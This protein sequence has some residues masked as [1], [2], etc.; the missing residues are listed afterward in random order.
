MFDVVLYSTIV[1]VCARQQFGR[2]D[3][4]DRWVGFVVVHDGNYTAI[5]V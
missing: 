4:L 5:I 1:D 3:G 2:D